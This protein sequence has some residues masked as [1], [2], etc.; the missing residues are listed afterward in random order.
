M[1]RLFVVV[2][3]LCFLIAVVSA[4]S[5]KTDGRVLIVNGVPAIRFASS[6]AGLSGSGRATHFANRLALTDSR[7]ITVKAARRWARLY[8]GGVQIAEVNRA[9]AKAYG[10]SPAALAKTWAARLRG[11][12]ALPGVRVSA[13]SFKL[14]TSAVRTTSLV[15]SHVDDATVRSTNEAVVR[16]EKVGQ[17]IQ[18]HT[19]CL[20]KAQV[21]V[22][23]GNDS[24]TI[25][26]SVL[27]Y[28]ANF[29]QVFESAVTGAPVTIETVRGSIRTALRNQFQALHGATWTYAVPTVERIPT[30][31]TRTF[32]VRV[33]V[34]APNAFPIEGQVAVTVRNVI[35]DNT[36]DAELW[37]CNKPESVRGPQELF[38]AVLAADIPARMLY[39]HMNASGSTLFVRIVAINPTDQPA[40][41]LVIPGNSEPGKNATLAGVQAADQFVRNWVVGSAEV[42]TIPPKSMLP[43]TLRRLYPKQIMSGLSSFRLLGGGP[44][45]IIVRAEAMPPFAVDARWNAAI[46]SSTPWREIGCQKM[47]NAEASILYP[48]EHVYAKPFLEKEVNYKVGDTKTIVRLGEKDEIQRRDRRVTLGGNYGVMYTLRTTIENPTDTVTQ[49]DLMFRASAGYSG[50]LF[51]IDGQVIRTPML[52]PGQEVKVLSINVQP[53]L[54]RFMVIQTLPLSGS[55][56]PATI[57]ILARPTPATTGAKQL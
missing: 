15:G 19:V 3:S 16:A 13:T 20:G 27:P 43:V 44:K 28:A 2:A 46:S 45:E 53:R 11:P 25:N 21:V 9:E 56:Y 30:G 7:T 10:V 41:I 18:I 42:V 50:G 32:K 31:N 54:R 49:V 48:S 6:A 26:V 40:Q 39:H 29:P 52:Q 35:V 17:G 57:S 36:R 23:G 33:K 24:Q 12:L 8:A 34:K 38:S 55:S 1:R 5:V 47:P 14:P 22:T 51:L 37:Y 4:A